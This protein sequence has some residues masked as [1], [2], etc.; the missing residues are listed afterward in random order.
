MLLSAVIVIAQLRKGRDNE[1]LGQPGLMTKI[2]RNP[3]SL[4]AFLE[5]LAVYTEAATSSSSTTLDTGSSGSRGIAAF[6]CTAMGGC[7]S[8]YPH[9]SCLILV[10][11][12]ANQMLTTTQTRAVLH[13][14]SC[15]IWFSLV[16]LKE[17]QTSTS[18][19]QR[20]PHGS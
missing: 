3:L 1:V 17:P 7:F 16:Q 9:F 8:R 13:V 6:V 10:P 2:F 20:P 14:Q 15:L 4:K 5:Y 11:W 19:S 12:R 18:C